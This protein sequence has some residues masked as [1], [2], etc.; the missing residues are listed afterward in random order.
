MLPA[1]IESAIPP[2]ERMQ[3][4]A[5]YRTATW[6]STNDICETE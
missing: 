6:I 3:N 5:L 4:Y 2:I 1:G